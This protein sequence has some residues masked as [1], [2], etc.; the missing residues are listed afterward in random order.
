MDSASQL[1]GV[2]LGLA[3]GNAWV[4]VALAILISAGLIAYWYRQPSEGISKTR[5]IILISLRVL[6]VAGL[7][8]MALRPVLRFTVE[9]SIR[10]SLVILLDNSASM[11][12]KDPRS[13]PDD[14]KRAAIGLNRLDPNGGL[15][16]PLP[17][18]SAAGLDQI[19]RIDL[20]KAVLKNQ[21][22]DL[23]QKLSRDYDLLPFG[24]G[25]TPRELV[26]PVQQAPAEKNK[27][28]LQFGWVDSLAADY[29]QTAIGEAV[30]EVLA[31]KRGQPLAGI[32]L[33]T[34]G[35]NNSG[36]PPLET[37]A[38]ARQE[39]V[40]IYIYG[41]GI[42]SPRDIIVAHLLA[43]DV[44]FA[45]DEVEAS[46]HIRHQ[47]MAGQTA[48]L[49]LRLAGKV[50]DEKSIEFG[51]DGEMVKTMKFTP[52][53][54]GHFELQASIEPRPDETVK[55]NNSL[56][57]NLRVIDDKIKVLLVEQY[58]RWEYRYLQAM[59]LRDR[60]IEAK[61]ILFSG[62]STISRAPNSPFLEK[63]PDR[64]EELFKYDVI[65]W[66]DIDPR[67]LTPAQMEN[68]GQFVSQFGGAFIMVAGKR[69]SPWAYKRTAIEK[70][71][72]VEFDPQPSE[73]VG[74]VVAE[75]PVALE[76]TAAGKNSAMLR[77]AEL[78]S[79]NQKIWRNLPPIYWVAS[80][81]RA[82][83]AAEVL[84]VDADASKATRFGKMP[85]I[86]IQQYGAGQ[87]L[88]VGT[89]NLWRLRKNEGDAIHVTLWGQMLQRMTLQRLLG[90]SKRTQL[91]TDRQNVTSGERITVY[92]RLFNVGYEPFTEPTVKAAY[93]LRNAP[94][95]GSPPETEVILHLAPDQPG[96]YRGEFTAPAPGDYKFFVQHDRDTPLNFSV[97]EPRYE[98]GETAM[99]ETLLGQMATNS[100]GRFFREE[101]L[102]DLPQTI[103]QKAERVRSTLEVEVW[104]SWFSYLLLLALLTAEWIG[105]KL[106]QL[107]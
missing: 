11:K 89:D 5:R 94:S 73:G 13:S 12:I 92:A 50:V 38:I 53:E 7:L 30:R 102:R 15:A 107:K 32:F 74:E 81:A 66:G 87:S 34:D 33:A 69:F 68:V 84:L 22:L 4:W 31:R 16:Q 104:S 8:F 88:F 100:G 47:G 91:V 72:P 9:G 106:S 60:R 20:L 48:R 44:A 2:K 57:R 55:D 99:N 51:P 105:R 90:G 95:G 41:V 98:L 61:I 18:D 58:P 45:N 71:L 75:K 25:T 3:A 43:P 14:L 40:P 54:K 103:G 67:L 46:V 6:F 63:F 37:A 19:S 76:L 64:K 21:R 1:S 82:K 85:V 17:P 86:A 26:A 56:S 101:N 97:A 35:A 29:P 27:P 28:Q 42:T 65:L 59:L 70:I 83:P 23:L 62:E 79:E 24:F 78:D 96:V 52:T 77:L 93:V 49:V 80:V 10:R 36:C 39:G